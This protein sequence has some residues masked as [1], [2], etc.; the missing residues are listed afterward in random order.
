[1]VKVY[2]YSPSITRRDAIGYSLSYL[3]KA[4]LRAGIPSFLV[5]DENVLAAAPPFT[6]AFQQLPRMGLA[7]DDIILFH[8]SYF[9]GN[10]NAL[11][12]LPCR[13][14]MIYHNITPGHFF[15][16]HGQAGVA[17]ACDAGRAFL[18]CMS[19][20]FD[21]VVADSAYN[22]AE[23][24]ACGY[25][26]PQVIPVFY[27]GKF[28]ADGSQDNDAFLRRRLAGDINL[29][30]I[31]RMV[32]NKRPD[33]LIRVASALKKMLGK[34]VRLRLHGKVWDVGYFRSLRRLSEQEGVEHEVNFE[35]NQPQASL[36][37]SLAAADAFVSMSEHEGFMVPLVEAFSAG[38]PVVALK[39]SAV[40]ETCG[41][42]GYLVDEPDVELVAGHIAAI[43]RDRDLRQNLIRAQSARAFDFSEQRTVSKWAALLRNFIPEPLVTHA[44]RV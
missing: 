27:N 44:H 31:G 9:D 40:T 24:A 21:A 2:H 25:P 14:I 17:D 16:N 12:A 42:A 30:F 37:T 18:P 15:R 10:S 38:C 19:G 3:H 4:M 34:P 41:P 20:A 11:A 35:I 28:Y 1:M 36:R 33:N 6:L 32:P 13:K 23:L 22:A 7:R 43:T 8:Y 39:S 5:C 29:A 26:S